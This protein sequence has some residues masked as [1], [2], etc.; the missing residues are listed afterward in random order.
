MLPSNVR[1]TLAIY[2]ITIKVFKVVLVAFVVAS[3]S[4]CG[5]ISVAF[6]ESLAVRY[7][8]NWTERMP[9][10]Y[11]VVVF[12]FLNLNHYRLSTENG[13][14]YSLFFEMTLSACF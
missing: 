13:I 7:L 5:L 11:N 12:E 10:K 4:L 9:R 1:L 3:K 8:M 6:E 14:L 2:I